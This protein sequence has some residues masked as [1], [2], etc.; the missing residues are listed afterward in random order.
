MDRKFKF[1]PYSYS[2]LSVF[3]GCPLR[4]KFQYIDKIK[5]EFRSEAL[6]KGSNVHEILEN[7]GTKKIEN[8]EADQIVRKFVKSEVASKYLRPLCR[9]EKSVREISIGLDTNL[10]PCEYKSKNAL[11]RGKI[12]FIC[13]ID[14]ALNLC[15]YKTGKY[16]EESYQDYR[17]LIFYALYFFK[18]YNIEKIRISYIYVEQNLENSMIL[19]RK[20]LSNYI[21]ALMTMINNVENASEYTKKIKFCSWC[22]YKNHCS[23]N[24]TKC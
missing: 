4:F 10:E 8:T 15:D 6:V 16:K 7:F 23:E 3:E 11:Y 17:Q 18:K 19:E 13:V 14:N 21:E 20:Y 22:P 5:Q 24:S 2:K 12:D 9:K 1:A